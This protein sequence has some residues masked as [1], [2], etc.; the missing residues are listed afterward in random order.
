MTGAAHKTGGGEGDDKDGEANQ[1]QDEGKPGKQGDA[2]QQ[3]RPARWPWLVASAIV[4]GFVAAVLWITLTPEPDPWTDDAY[5]QVH[6]A[7]VAPRVSGQVEDVLVDDNQTVK[8][9]QLLV[10]LDPRDYQTAVAEAQAAVARDKAQVTDAAANVARQPPLIDQQQAQVRQAQARLVLAQANQRRYSNL[11]ATGA[12]T[13]Q[14]R[15]DAD[16]DLKTATATL[17]G[18]QSQLVATQRQLDVLKAQQTSAEVNV[19]ADEA[20]LEQ[21]NLNLSYTEIRAP[22]GAM[23]AQRSV[24]VGDIVSP[25]AAMMAAVPLNRIYITANYR[26]TALRHVLPGQ[27]VRIHVDAYDIDLAGVVDSIPPASGTTFSPVPPNNA[28]GNFTKIV[29]RLPVKIVVAP[30]Q[31][32]ARLLR[33]GF[34]VETTIRTHLADVAAAQVGSDQRVTSH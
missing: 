26:E 8:A 32:L 13:Q 5:V 12:G 9:G 11:A 10:R 31:P 20:R 23:V 30:D 16:T 14:Q 17:F 34:S 21:A 1:K 2:N 18:A 19:K 33:V 15:Q 22:M 29:Q 7:T 28:T 4:I 3:P 27:A 6:Y 25:G 24:Q